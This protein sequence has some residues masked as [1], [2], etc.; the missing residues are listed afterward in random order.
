MLAKFAEKRWAVYIA[1]AVDR[2]ARWV[3][4]VAPADM[5][6]IAD[7]ERDGASG[8]ITKPTFSKK[9]PI[10]LDRSNMPPLDVSSWPSP[11]LSNGT[12]A[13]LM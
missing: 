12:V 3:E 13:D 7:F 11:L 9:Q 2:F 4:A 6:S 1:R 5:P 10:R 8:D